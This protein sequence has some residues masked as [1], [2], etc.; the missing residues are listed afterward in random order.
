MESQ[1]DERREVVSG[2]KLSAQKSEK[3][4]YFEANYERQFHEKIGIFFK[5]CGLFLIRRPQFLERSRLI[6]EVVVP[7]GELSTPD[8]KS[9]TFFE[10]KPKFS[11]NS[12]RFL[13]NLLNFFR[14]RSQ[15]ANQP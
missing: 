12:T 15:S 4:A 14:V 1:S 6:P 8:E 10:K 9:A 5:K 3:L 11:L 7:T 2:S 13:E